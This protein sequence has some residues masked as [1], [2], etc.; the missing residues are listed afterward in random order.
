MAHRVW[1]IIG[2]G[3]LVIAGPLLSVGAFLVPDEFRIEYLVTVIGV[4]LAIITFFAQ[5]NRTTLARL[6]EGTKGVARIRMFEKDDFYS[7]WRGALEAAKVAHIMYMDVVPPGG[8]AG[9]VKGAYYDNFVKLVRKSGTT[10]RRLDRAHQATW[11]WIEQVVEGLGSQSTFSYAV[12]TGD[13]PG[14]SVQILD[15]E[16]TFLVAIGRQVAYSGKRDAHVQSKEF[17]AA[18][19]HYYNHLWSKSV[20]LIDRGRINT[21][22]LENL[23][24]QYGP[25]P[26]RKRS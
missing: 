12:W 20:V 5:A 13:E 3:I 1:A 17:G 2:L 10:T 16:H 8:P 11:P 9:S 19:L 21:G 6:E 26:G 14:L 15:D 24:K 7:E 22:N 25:K 4:P 18:W 23:R